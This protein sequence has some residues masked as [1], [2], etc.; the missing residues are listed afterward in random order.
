MRL[1]AILGIAALSALPVLAS[2]SGEPQ[3][4][5]YFLI[6]GSAVIQTVDDHTIRIAVHS[7]GLSGDT[8]TGAVDHVFYFWYGKVLRHLDVSTESAGIEYRGDQLTVLAADHEWYYVFDVSP[9]EPREG[10]LVHG[11]MGEDP[12]RSRVRAD[13]PPG[14]AYMIFHGYGL[15]HQMGAVVNARKLVFGAPHVLDC[16]ECGPLSP[17]PGGGGGSG[18]S[19]CNSGGSGSTSC[20]ITSNG[21]SCSVSCGS[22]Y[23]ACCNRNSGSPTCYYNPN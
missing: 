18:G 14:F 17:D 5:D 11:N 8:P 15:N 22:G 6:R 3:A 21:N 2:P 7:F 16:D 23:Y 9:A 20:S 13:V 1:R 4:S 10:P 19:S 12:G